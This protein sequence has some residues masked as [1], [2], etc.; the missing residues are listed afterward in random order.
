MPQGF[1][2]DVTS[3]SLV[4]LENLTCSSFPKFPNRLERL[5]TGFHISFDK[6]Y[7]NRKLRHHKPFGCGNKTHL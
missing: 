2:V 6:L 4:V 7:V 5:D 1:G 3:P